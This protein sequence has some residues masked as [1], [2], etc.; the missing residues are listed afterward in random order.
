[1]ARETNCMIK[2]IAEEIRFQNAEDFTRMLRIAVEAAENASLGILK[3]ESVTVA[4]KGYVTTITF[5]NHA[6][7]D[8][9]RIL[10]GTTNFILVTDER[11]ETLADYCSHYQKTEYPI[12][13]TATT[14]DFCYKCHT[15]I[16]GNVTEIAVSRSEIHF[17][18]EFCT[19]D[20][21]APLPFALT[22]LG[23]IEFIFNNV[24]QWLAGL[25]PGGERC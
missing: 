21:D 7:A 19:L 3:V 15:Q 12:T 2:L 18:C 1:M 13:R 23:E 4:G 8:V 6:H 25:A 11:Q 20:P 17:V 14:D 24:N 10:E 5:D 22:E 16:T 9:F